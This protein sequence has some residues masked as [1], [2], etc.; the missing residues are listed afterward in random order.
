MDKLLATVADD[1]ELQAQIQALIFD[2]T[3]TPAATSK[4]IPPTKLPYAETSTPQSISVAEQIRRLRQQLNTAH[5]NFVNAR[6]SLA[7]ISF[8]GIEKHFRQQSD[9]VLHATNLPEPPHYDDD[10]DALSSTSSTAQATDTDSEDRRPPATAAQLAGMLQYRVGDV[11]QLSKFFRVVGDLQTAIER[12]ERTHGAW[13]N[14][15]A[16]VQQSL[17]Q[18]GEYVTQVQQYVDAA[19]EGAGV[20]EAEQV[21]LERT[22]DEEMEMVKML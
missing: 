22:V 10:D 17:Q 14:L 9:T 13:A 5:A 7:S 4:S 21:E 3:P 19:A 1:A 15:N 8:V 20:T 2:D 16:D 11:P 18:N 12:M 6:D